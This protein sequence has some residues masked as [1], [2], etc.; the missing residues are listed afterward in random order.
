MPRMPWHPQWSSRRM[1]GGRTTDKRLTTRVSFCERMTSL[2]VSRWAQTQ[3]QESAPAIVAAPP[4][5]PMIDQE[6]TI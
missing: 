3:L 1:S 2:V 5:P 4:W 6:R